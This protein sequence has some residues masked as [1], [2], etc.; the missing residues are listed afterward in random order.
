[1]YSYVVEYQITES[2]RLT[3]AFDGSDFVNRR[4]AVI[5]DLSSF[6]G[7]SLTAATAVLSALGHRV[8][9][10]PTAV[11]S[12]QSEFAVHV[13]QDLTALM[14]RYAAA[15]Q[16]NGER[17]D[18]ICTG[19]FADGVQLKHALRFLD[20]F[21]TE[22]TLVA[23]DPVMGDDGAL[24]PSY[25]RSACAAMKALAARASCLTPN[26]TE[27]CLL[28]D[29]D[30]AAVTAHCRK[31]D[32]LERIAAVAAPLS[33]GSC[34]IVTG[35]PRD[36]RLYNLTVQNGTFEAAAVKQIGARFSGTGDLFAAVVS[37]CL[38]NGAAAAD[39]VRAAAQFV[40]TCVADTVKEPYDPLYGVNFEQNLRLLT[41]MI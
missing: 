1:M 4:I 5:N 13:R 15:W 29:T 22:E 8:C 26:L 40:E 9:A 23:V 27:L 24:Y 16:Q 21:Q 7:C 6:G 30:Y 2:C 19:Y 3:E 31:A 41:E 17:F 32:F 28:T 14:P 33:R 35:I 34:V 37:G 36:G 39:A 20:L 11:L 25:D 38:L 10:L 18:G 12:A